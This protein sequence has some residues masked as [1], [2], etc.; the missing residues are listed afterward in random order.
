M[1]TFGE[2]LAN[3]LKLASSREFAWS[4]LQTGEQF[5]KKWFQLRLIRIR[6]GVRVRVMVRVN[7]TPITLAFKMLRILD[8]SSLKEKYNAAK[9]RLPHCYRV[10]EH[11]CT[12]VGQ[13]PHYCRWYSWFL[14]PPPLS[15]YHLQYLSMAAS[16]VVVT[17]FKPKLKGIELH[18]RYK[19]TTS[20]K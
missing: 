19:M 12:S 7:S 2:Y 8:Q 13:A 5:V 11:C 4:S 9:T 14:H 6:V 20:L 17:K 15:Q 3:T 1:W 10:Q 18:Q 16:L